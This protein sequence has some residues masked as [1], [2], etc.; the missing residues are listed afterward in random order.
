MLL[1]YRTC[2]RHS[3][4]PLAPACAGGRCRS[5]RLDRC[6]ERLA[7]RPCITKS[8]KCR[9][10]RI[11]VGTDPLRVDEDAYGNLI[12]RKADNSL[13]T[14]AD[15][16]TS[17]LY[18]GEQTDAN[19]TQYLR[20]R[21]YDPS[22]G[23]FNRLDPF[24][25]NASDPQSLHKYLYAHANPVMNI[26]P[27]G[28][29][30]LVGLSAGFAIS[31]NIRSTK[32]EADLFAFDVAS[33]TILGISSGATADEVFFSFL[34]N[35]AVG[36]GAGAALGTVVRGAG[37]L[38]DD[39]LSARSAAR[40]AAGLGDEIAAA[41]RLRALQQGGPQ[42]AHFF[43]RHGAGTTIEQQYNRAVLGR[44]PDGGWRRP[45]DASRFLTH[46]QQLAAYEQAVVIHRQT[47][48]T[49]VTFDAGGIVG[50]GF[51][52]GG[53]DY[54]LTSNVQAFFDSNGDMITMFPL[55]RPL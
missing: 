29:L 21:Y 25:G 18:S 34:F 41:R 43:S 11:C 3:R 5:T 26:D 2:R 9:A 14:V 50:E 16:V 33:T 7:S 24:A 22:N 6:L 48:R 44:L 45:V 47:G 54:V 20:A 46:K 49:S 40:N 30:A 4:G 17:I 51:T 1:P 37:K 28:E 36:F 32:N 10:K 35:Q 53:D 19:G 23:R 42:N 38:I 52:K 8:D 39:A 31:S 12:N 13:F 27:S 15:A 55:L